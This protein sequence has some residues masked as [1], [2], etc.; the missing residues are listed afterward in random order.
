MSGAASATALTATAAAGATA[1][2]AAAITVGT[3]AATGGLFGTG[4]SAMTAFSALATGASGLSALSSFSNAR[5]Q[6]VY[7]KSAGQMEAA[8]YAQQ[9][10][11]ESLR[12]S[13][14][15]ANRQRRLSEILSSQAAYGAGRGVS[16][17]SGSILAIQDESLAAAGRE[18]KLGAFDSNYK[19]SMLNAQARQSFISGKAGKSAANAQ[20]FSSL[21]S[22]GESALNRTRTT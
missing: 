1:G 18:S 13:Q 8:Q 14:E 5:A 22:F 4:I 7:A 16:V 2:S 19:K 11:M 10:E 21:L 17:G 15:E 20:G 3:A 12:A 6:G 9:A